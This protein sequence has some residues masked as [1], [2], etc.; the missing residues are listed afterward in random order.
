MEDVGYTG[1]AYQIPL[2]QYL[3]PSA[4][5]YPSMNKIL[6][7]VAL[8]SC[9]VRLTAQ[10]RFYVAADAAGANTGHSWIN[11]FTDLHNALALAMPGDEIWVAEGYYLPSTTGDRTARFEL[12][13]GVKIIGGFTGTETNLDERGDPTIHPTTISGNTGSPADT[14]DNSFTL[15]YCLQ[16]DSSTL[17]D[18]FIF[19]DAVANKTGISSI[20]VGG[21]GAAIYIQANNNYAYITIR[22]C[23]FE[24]NTA[25]NNGAGIFVNGFG[26]ASVS[27]MIKNCHFEKNRSLQRGGAVYWHGGSL[28]ERPDNFRNCTFIRNYAGQGAG[29]YWWDGPGIDTM[30][31]QDCYFESNSAGLYGSALLIDEM[32]LPQS[33]IKLINTVLTKHED[34]SVLEAFPG[35]F[36]GKMEV[37]IKNCTVS[38]NFNLSSANRLIFLEL[39]DGLNIHLDS[40]FVTKNPTGYGSIYFYSSIES[41]YAFNNLFF[42]GNTGGTFIGTSSTTTI[43]EINNLSV[44]N[45]EGTYFS[46]AN[47]NNVFAYN[48]SGFILNTNQINNSVFSKIINADQ[49]ASLYAGIIKYNNCIFDNI[50][51]YHAQINGDTLYYKNLLDLQRNQTFNHCIFTDTIHR[52]GPPGNPSFTFNN[53]LFHTNPQFVAPSA[54]DLRLQPCSP[55][56]HFGIDSAVLANHITKDLDGKPRILG[57]R[58]DLGPFETNPAGTS[59]PPEIK[60]ACAGG[61]N[62][63]IDFI[64]DGGCPPYQYEWSTSG[65]TEGHIDALPPGNYTVTITDSRSST[66]VLSFIVPAGAAPVPAAQTSP[67]FCGTTLGGTATF[68]VSNGIQPFQFDWGNGIITDSM[69]TGLPYGLYTVTVTDS[70][71]CTGIGTAQI[72]RVGNLQINIVKT[73]ISCYSD[74]NG[75]ILI[76]PDNGA[77]PFEWLWDDGTTENSISNLMPGMYSGTL[78]DALGCGINWVVSLEEPD[79]IQIPFVITPATGPAEPDGSILLNPTGG[80]GNFTVDWSHG[81]SGSTLNNVLPGIYTASLT[82]ENGCTKA[83]SIEVKWTSATDEHTLSPV[84]IWPDPADEWV[85]V[86][87]V[88]DTGPLQ[89]MLLNTTGQVIRNIFRDQSGAFSLWTGDL[90]AGHY[91]WQLHSGKGKFSGGIIIQ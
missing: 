75:A 52:Q 46:A 30:D 39:L 33:N 67:V 49:S 85:W 66:N 89:F 5:S 7:I 65:G 12:S 10:E 37:T 29:I 72:S 71:G 79:S 13:S 31:I 81:P 2:I 48:N 40:L 38:E 91:F 24:H 11:A 70:N 69:R 21:S 1:F 59:A 34:K 88:Q 45:N 8:I 43:T 57:G 56:V 44:K 61:M 54:G 73:P 4:H 32:R 18:G 42:N 26:D 17:I 86:A 19:R 74:T 9:A 80:T 84:K 53:T 22:N 55:G 68:S 16:P 78:T 15:M 50:F 27:P 25:K 20:D 60:A 63:S 14:I 90:P 62:G 83:I 41:Y 23:R 28:V 47:I 87:P 36:S 51:Y 77:A 6:F 76:N 35:L 58:V 64:T 82:D 3:Q